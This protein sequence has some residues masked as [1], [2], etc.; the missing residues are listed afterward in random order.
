MTIKEEYSKEFDPKDVITITNMNKTSPYLPNSLNPQAININS[1]KLP[2]VPTLG[3]QSFLKL[4]IKD[5]KPVMVGLVY[6]ISQ[7]SQSAAT[8]IWG[9][10]LVVF[11]GNG[12][13]T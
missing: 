6:T 10:C 3:P 7:P 13:D 8:V 12:R 5:C 2:S 1:N 9:V 11:G 4:F